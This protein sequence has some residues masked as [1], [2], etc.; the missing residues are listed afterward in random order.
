MEYDN[1]NKGA[2]FR[3]DKRTSDR[4]PEYG[5]SINVNGVDY[6]ISGWIK[7]GQKGKFFSLSV[8]PKDQQKASAPQQSRQAAPPVSTED[9]PFARRKDY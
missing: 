3:N 2:L 6:W 4:A 9:I 1:S 5:G 8:Q 7:E